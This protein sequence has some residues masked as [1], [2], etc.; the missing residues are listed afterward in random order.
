MNNNKT[1]VVLMLLWAGAFILLFLMLNKLPVETVMNWITRLSPMQWVNW[2]MLNC[3]II[4]IYVVR[5]SLINLGIE[6][7]SGFL[8]LLMVRQAGQSFSFITPGPQFGGEPLQIFW[9][10][11]NNDQPGYKAFLSV[12]LDRFFELWINFAVLLF[13]IVVLIIFSNTDSTLWYYPLL[14]VLIFCV[15]LFQLGKTMMGND[16]IVI[17]WIKKITSRWKNSPRLKELGVHLENISS[18]VHGF[19]INKRKLFILAMLFSVIGWVGMLVELELILIFLDIDLSVT[20]FVFLVIAMRL[21][22]LLPVPGGVGTMEASVFWV[23]TSLGLNTFD[24]MGMITLIR[25]RDLVVMLSG[26]VAFHLLMRRSTGLDAT[27]IN[28]K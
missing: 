9:L 20:E 8:H 21:A 6:F 5:W 7:R 23:F 22:L 2:G 10:W 28:P 16:S 26:M 14:A 13:G 17:K 27:Y 11:K 19:M 18:D 24:V 1:R 25:F 4:L 12:A 15:A 3:I